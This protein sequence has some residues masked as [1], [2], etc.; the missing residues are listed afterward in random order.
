M[1][2][3]Y[4]SGIALGAAANAATVNAPLGQLDAA[5]ASLAT[6]L[7]IATVASG[8]VS[9]L[10][11]FNVK[12]YGATGDGTTDDTADVQAAIDAAAAVG[13]VVLF[14]KG[15]Y[16][17]GGIVSTSS[18][19]LVGQGRGTILKLKDG[20]SAGLTGGIWLAFSGDDG[21][22]VADLTLDGNDANNTTLYRAL[23]F[24]TATN[25]DIHNIYAH[26]VYGQ[27]IGMATVD[28]FIIDNVVFYDITGAGGNPGEGVYAYACSNGVISNLNGRDIDDHLTYISG[29]ADNPSRSITITNCIGYNCGRVTLQAAFNVFQECYGVEMSNCIS[30]TSAI[31]FTINSAYTYVCNRITLINC[32]ALNSTKSGFTVAGIQDN[33][34]LMDVVLTGC[35]AVGSGRGAANQAFGINIVDV[36]GVTLNGC[37]SWGSNDD[38]MR[39]LRCSQF[40]INGG[41]YNDNGVRSNV[42]AGIRLRDSVNGNLNGVRAVDTRS[43]G[44]RTQAFGLLPQG[45]TANVT[46]HGGDYTNNVTNGWVRD[47]TLSATCRVIDVGVDGSQRTR[48]W[49]TDAPTTGTWAVGD[50]VVNTT[51]TR[52]LNIAHWTCYTA[53]TPG[54]WMA[55][56]MGWGTTAERT[57]L[58]LDGR[59][60][61]YAFFD[62][63]L[64]EVAIWNGGAWAT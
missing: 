59:D 43:G 1:T 39:L 13:G 19:N 11:M 20:A 55:Y 41:Q 27:A 9:S 31:G 18:V 34:E 45:T 7:S 24:V 46:V 30:D 6:Q 61:G 15:T 33:T 56:G 48:I 60:A 62:T 64:G 25:V 51:P 54:S 26:D 52:I 49:G 12:A 10:E 14:P 63:T 58:S 2:Q 37:E 44:S 35:V 21:F 50:T 38:G 8:N 57:G 32:L 17:L 53:G 3:N 23:Y 36:N 5:I 29:S 42:F 16:I 22:T 4:H 40:A 28:R 47:T